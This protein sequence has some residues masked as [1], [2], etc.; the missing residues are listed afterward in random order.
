MKGQKPQQGWKTH[1]RWLYERLQEKA[2]KYKRKLQ[3]RK[4]K[5][6]KIY[7]EGD[8]TDSR[9]YGDYNEF[10]SVGLEQLGFGNGM[11]DAFR[12]IAPKNRPLRILEDGAGAGI[13]L[14]GIKEELS[15][16]G[17][18]SITTAI[19][20]HD[21]PLLMERQRLGKIDRVAFGNA[22]L[23]M[24][25]KSQDCIISMMG[26]LNYTISELRKDTLLKFAHSLTRGGL[27]MVGFHF[28][29]KPYGTYNIPRGLSEHP[30]A[31]R[32]LPIKDEMTGI[33]KAFA[34]R[35]FHAKF[36]H[37]EYREGTNFPEWMLIVKRLK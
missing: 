18:K 1:A 33:E 30:K 36:I 8:W 21:Y 32:K 10:F 20:L 5:L 31:G 26:T 37:F 22:E 16:A 13:D 7:E 34:K 3:R 29:T 23:F 17:I 6:T 4:G 27:M 15:K 25:E 35:G 2:T 12:R 19:S 14:E 11:V 24:P 28:T 9:T